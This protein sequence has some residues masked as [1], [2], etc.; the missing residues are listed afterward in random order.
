MLECVLDLANE[1]K[2]EK[3]GS[4]LVSL[5]YYRQPEKLPAFISMLTKF[6]YTGSCGQ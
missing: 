1:V 4:S 5:F 3:V 6:T 2:A